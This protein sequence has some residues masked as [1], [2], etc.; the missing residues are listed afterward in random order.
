MFA[1]GKGM[2]AATATASGITEV[3]PGMTVVGIAGMTAEEMDNRMDRPAVTPRRSTWFVAKTAVEK[4]P[5][6]YCSV[7]TGKRGTKVAMT[8]VQEGKSS[9]P[10][11]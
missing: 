10:I 5:G 7:V 11:L 4:N 8:G 6:G 9:S 3:N 2:S 1:A